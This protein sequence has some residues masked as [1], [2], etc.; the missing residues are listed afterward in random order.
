MH[1]VLNL[2]PCLLQIPGTS[3]ELD[4]KITRGDLL[5]SVN[6][7]NIENVTSEEAGAI[8]KTAMGRVSLKLYRYKPSTSNQ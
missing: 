6:G 8:L 1:F 7:Q 5:I 2:R 3:A 4:G